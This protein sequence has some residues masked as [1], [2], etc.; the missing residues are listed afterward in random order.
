M[1]DISPESTTWTIQGGHTLPEIPL[2]WEDFDWSLEKL[3][4]KPYGKKTRE[5]STHNYNYGNN[6][7]GLFANLQ[8][9]VSY[10]SSGDGVARSTINSNRHSCKKRC[11]HDFNINKYITSFLLQ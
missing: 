11:E 9:L 4:H 6:Y 10:Q 1:A 2:K 7:Y 8:G 5:R 3:R